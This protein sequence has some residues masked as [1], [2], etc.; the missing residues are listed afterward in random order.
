MSALASAARGLARLSPGRA[1]FVCY[2]IWYLAMM[3]SYGSAAPQIWLTAL[4]MGVIVGLGFV[5]S[6]MASL[7]SPEGGYWPV[8]RIFLIPFCVSSFSSV[9][10]SEDFLLIFAPDAGANLAAAAACLVFLLLWRMAR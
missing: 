7:R 4:G 3:A 1:A 10:T 2:G 8:V 5:L 6:G 9:A